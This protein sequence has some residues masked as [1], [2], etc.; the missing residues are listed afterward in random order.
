MKRNLVYLAIVNNRSN[1]QME[2]LF[3]LC[4]KDLSMLLELLAKLKDNFLHYCPST[5]EER[6]GVLKLSLLEDQKDHK[7]KTQ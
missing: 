5:L 4:G 1:G 7:N 6:D 2:F 3:D